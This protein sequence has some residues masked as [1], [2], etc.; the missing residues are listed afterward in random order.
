MLCII[1]FWELR[2]VC[3]KLK[4]GWGK[5]NTSVVDVHFSD[6]LEFKKLALYFPGVSICDKKY[7]FTLNSLPL[8]PGI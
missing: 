3:H 5:S 6:T 2:G 4:Y 1:T 7:K 8:S